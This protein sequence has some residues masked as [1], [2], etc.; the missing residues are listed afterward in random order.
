MRA[1]FVRVACLPF[2]MDEWVSRFCLFVVSEV[3][4]FGLG[5]WVVV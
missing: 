3:L 2:D 1:W 5:C 4:Y